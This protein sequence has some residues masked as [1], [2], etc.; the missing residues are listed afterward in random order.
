MTIARAVTA[1]EASQRADH[2]V[3]SDRLRQVGPAHQCGIDRGSAGS[4]F[5]DGPDHETGPAGRVSACEHAFSRSTPAVVDRDPAAEWFGRRAQLAQQFRDI[6]S[7]E[8]RCEENEFRR[9]LRPRAWARAE[10]SP[11]V[12]PK[13]PR[14]LRQHRTHRRSLLRKNTDT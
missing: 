1:A 4:A 11:T 14:I 10:L 5:G 8:P 9:E 3:G 6:S 12:P 7:D 13:I 2:R